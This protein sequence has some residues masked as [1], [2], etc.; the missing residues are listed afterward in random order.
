M[1]KVGS[2]GVF[3]QK[4]IS[5]LGSAFSLGIVDETEGVSI[6]TQ[7]TYCCYLSTSFVTGRRLKLGHAK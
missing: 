5:L 4:K 7:M 2:D 3:P 1:D 6:Y